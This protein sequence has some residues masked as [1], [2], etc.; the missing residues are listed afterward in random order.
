[1][2]GQLSIAAA[3]ATISLNKTAA[4]GASAIYGVSNSIVKWLLQLGN[5]E[6]ESG[7]N[8]GFNF[9]LHRYS[10]TGVLLGESLRINRQ[11]GLVSTTGDVWISKGDPA[12]SLDRSAAGQSGGL[13]GRVASKGR[14]GLFLGDGTAETGGNLGSNF[15]I[16]R[17]NDAGAYIDTPFAIRRNTGRVEITNHI[18]LPTNGSTIT[19][20]GGSAI[21]RSGN[22]LFFNLNDDW[23]H[24]INGENGLRVWDGYPGNRSLM[25]LDGNANLWVA[26]SITSPAFLASP[27]LRGG[28]GG[29]GNL[30]AFGGNNLIN[31]RWDGP[32]GYIT[33]RVDEAVEQ[34]LSNTPSDERLKE[35]IKPTSIDALSVV[36]A[37]EVSEY[38]WCALGS[39]DDKVRQAPRHVSIGMVAQKLQAN[40]PDAVMINKQPEGRPEWM[41]EDLHY[42]RQEAQIAYLW[43][44]IQQ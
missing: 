1:M 30:R 22:Y 42:P 38:D 24:Y 37:T 34:V 43:R 23:R 31:F 28:P 12:L 5:S 33:G 16:A 18:D 2:G 11:T 36:M 8:A 35:N 27:E 15:A 20:Y 10:D 19:L 25:T 41:P 39:D 26:N 13:Y 4:G 3:S 21:Q 17:Y 7:S 32:N 9:T 6:V 44:S 40:A 29:S 14:W